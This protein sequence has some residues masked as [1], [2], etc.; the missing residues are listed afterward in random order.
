MDEK[1]MTDE[2]LQGLLAGQADEVAVPEGFSRAVISRLKEEH[3]SV[4]DSRPWWKSWAVPAWSLAAAALAAVLVLKAPWAGEKHQPA[5]APS[6]VCQRVV[7]PRSGEP[8]CISFALKKPGDVRF[9][10]FASN[11]KSIV[12]MQ[13]KGVAAGAHQLYWNG[14]DVHDR[15]VASRSFTIVIKTDEYTVRQEILKDP[16]C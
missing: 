11:G 10:V 2:E 16:A 3:A 6:Q 13:Q 5:P 7:C 4:N 1:N 15:E 12:A 9:E 8:A 14:L